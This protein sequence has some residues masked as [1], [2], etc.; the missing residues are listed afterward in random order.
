MSGNVGMEVARGAGPIELMYLILG[1]A[2]AVD[3]GLDVGR[4]IAVRSAIDV[5]VRI[6]A[7]KGRQEVAVNHFERWRRRRRFLR[8]YGL[9]ILVVLTDVDENGV[10]DVFGEVPLGCVLRSERVAI[11]RGNRRS[12]RPPRLKAM[13]TPDC[14][15]MSTSALT[16]RA[17]TH[18]QLR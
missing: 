13:P 2:L 7:T 6:L 15:T 16:V 5:D 10:R 8:P 17:K 4:Q 11:D 18:A 3:D 14:A 12:R 9:G 1:S